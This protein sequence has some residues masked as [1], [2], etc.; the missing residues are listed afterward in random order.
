MDER[1]K[2]RL[3]GAAVLVALAVIF[4][5][6]LLDGQPRQSERTVRLGLPERP[7]FQGEGETIVLLEE[8]RVK[9]PQ[10]EPSDTMPVLLPAVPD[11]TKEDSHVPEA[12]PAEPDQAQLPAE[13]LLS[14]DSPQ[15]EVT[16]EEKQSPDEQRET[17]RPAVI[18]RSTETIDEPPARP[19]S[20]LAT[21]DSPPQPESLTGRRT[22]A[23]HVRGWWLQLGVFSL[24]ENADRLLKQAQQAGFPCQKQGFQSGARSLH[25]VQCGPW[26]DRDAALAQR[27]PLLQRLQLKEAHLFQAEAMPAQLQSRTDV[28]PPLQGWAVQVGSFKSRSNADRLV[29]RLRKQGFPAYMEPLKR[30]QG[31]HYRVRIGPYAG[32]DEAERVRRRLASKANIST[33]MVVKHP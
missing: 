10:V 8:P 30:N 27:E 23:V 4:L 15:V 22:D 12:R 31:T 9:E 21:P 13:N 32:K 14:A 5:P 26:A 17:H 3:V 11:G 25:R 2:Q 20:T 18:V 7:V 29:E 16:E 33:A 28:T 24:K 6:M 1:L 19:S